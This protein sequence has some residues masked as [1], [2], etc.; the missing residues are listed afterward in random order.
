[1]MH[2]RTL[3][4]SGL[5]ICG[6]LA[7]QTSTSDCDGSIQLCG[8]IYTETTAPLGTG[9]VYEFTGACNLNLESASIWYTFTVQE[10]GDLSFVLD[11]ANDLDDYDWGL[12]DIT[13]GGCAGINAQ[14][15]TSPEVQC[16][17][18]GTFSTNGPT[19]ISSQFGGT[20][21]TNGPGNLNGPPFNA[22]LPVQVGQTYALVVMNWTGSTSGYTIDFTQSTAS[23]YDEN[24]PSVISVTTDCSNQNFSL[25]FSEPI[26]TAS[27]EPLDFSLTSPSGNSMA[28]TA[29]NPDDPGA[30]AQSGFSI[31]LADVPTEGGMYTLTITSVSGNVQ[32]LCG[33][34][35]LDTVLQVPITAPLAYAV[36]ITTACNGTGGAVQVNY[37]SGGHPPMVFYLNGSTMPGGTAS[38]LVPGDYGLQATDSIGCQVF[39][40]IT[41]PDHAIDL[42][43]PQDQDSLSCSNPL[44]TIS[45]VEVL[46]P[47]N[48][49]YLWT[50]ETAA[51]TDP[52]F[53]TH[54]DPEV[55]QAGI[56]TL[57]VTDPES[58]CSDQASVTIIATDLTI[59]DLSSVVLPNVVSPN[60]DGKNDTWHPFLPSAPDMEITHLFDEYSLVVYD[61]WGMPVY[62]TGSNGARSWNPRGSADGTYFYTIAFRSECGTLVDKEL[63]GTITV[64]R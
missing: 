26:I 24:P 23:I 20:G 50:A 4:L 47:Q 46:P 16:N 31:Q 45:G 15:G 43:L 10:E 61:R 17:S 57:L 6:T 48:V 59:L 58:G 37:L 29:V 32:D 1:M 33:N 35:V 12:F 2:L 13:N 28:F 18:Y 8:G 60:G 11:P 41:V 36:D 64:L 9:N 63:S 39:E 3:S 51:G 49:E 54:P 27:V 53:S 62:E 42:V 7:A 38:G 19:G 40:F 56:Y 55:Q 21:T 5:A 25:E 14:D 30:N 22:D 34:T 52:Q 44:V